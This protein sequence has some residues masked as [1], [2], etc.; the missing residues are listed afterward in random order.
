MG[1]P[2]IERFRAYAKA[3]K[4]KIGDKAKGTMSLSVNVKESC[5]QGALPASGKPLFTNWLKIDLASGYL[6]TAVDYDVKKIFKDKPLT[7]IYLPAS[8]RCMLAA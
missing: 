2:R 6:L 4:A 8:R 5:R 7:E 1:I 3:L